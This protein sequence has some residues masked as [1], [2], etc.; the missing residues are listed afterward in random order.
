MATPKAGAK[1]A[2]RAA[3]AAEFDP[4]L[5]DASRVAQLEDI[6]RDPTFLAE[7]IRGFTNDVESLL[8]RTHE[9]LDGGDGDALSDLMHTLKGAAVSVG[10]IRL[11]ALTREFDTRVGAGSAEDAEAAFADLRSCFEATAAALR[12]YL[13]VQHHASI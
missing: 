9:T 13:R 12:E 2:A 7:L 4:T 10:A 8:V 1:P 6:A 11:A 3:P 5:I